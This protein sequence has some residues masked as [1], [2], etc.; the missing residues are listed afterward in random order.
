MQPRGLGVEAPR[1]AGE[2]G[3]GRTRAPPAERPRRGAAGPKRANRSTVARILF[4][5]GLNNSRAAF[6]AYAE[7]HEGKRKRRLMAKVASLPSAEG[8]EA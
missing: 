6:A 1:P 2:A 3:L 4:F 7:K 5:Y 8:E